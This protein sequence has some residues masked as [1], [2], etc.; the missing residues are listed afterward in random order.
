LSEWTRPE[1]K[2]KKGILSWYSR[3]VTSSD[4]GAILT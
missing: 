3:N 2:Y 1:P 4:R